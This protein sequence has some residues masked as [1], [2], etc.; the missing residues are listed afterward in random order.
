MYADEYTLSRRQ[1]HFHK[2]SRTWF[3]ADLSVKICPDTG[4]GD[5]EEPVLGRVFFDRDR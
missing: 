2:G 5:A 4:L 1:T 3:F